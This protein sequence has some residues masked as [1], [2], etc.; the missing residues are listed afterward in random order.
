MADENKGGGEEFSKDLLDEAL[1]EFDAGGGFTGKPKGINASQPKPATVS[2]PPSPKPVTP[3]SQGT[4]P[5]QKK[6]VIDDEF[7]HFDDEDEEDASPPPQQRRAQ[8][9]PR[10]SGRRAKPSVP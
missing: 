2:Q 8:R 4:K 9:R 6:P 10:R 7:P 3:P 5:A 1:K